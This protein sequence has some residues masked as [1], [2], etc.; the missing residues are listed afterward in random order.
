MKNGKYKQEF[1]EFMV[2]C[3]VIKIWRLRDKERK[4][5]PVFRKH[6]ILSHRRLARS[7]A[8]TTRRRSMTHSEQTSMFSLDRLTREFR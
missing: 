5:D 1:I 7:S 4:K 6:R 8:S 3:G 2:D